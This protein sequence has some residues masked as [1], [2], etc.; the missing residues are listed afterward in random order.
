MSQES[1]AATQQAQ[2]DE[3]VTLDESSN[4]QEMFLG[5]LKITDGNTLSFCQWTV[6]GNAGKWTYSAIM[7]LSSG[8]NHR[9]A[10]GHKADGSF[11]HEAQA[12]SKE[13]ALAAVKAR[14]MAFLKRQP[15]WRV[16]A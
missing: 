6:V 5:K 8:T 7:P 9:I 1:E 12:D 4:A 11:S 16:I 3:T 15:R 13:A 10:M 2:P 14:I